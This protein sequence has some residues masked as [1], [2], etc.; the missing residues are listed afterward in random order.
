MLLLTGIIIF[1]TC[2]KN[3]DLSRNPCETKTEILAPRGYEINTI[4]EIDF[5]G[6]VKTFQFVNEQVG[7]VLAGNNRGG[8]VDVLKTT[9]GGKNWVDLNISQTQNFRGMIFKNENLGVITVHDIEGCP[10]PNCKNKCVILKTEDGGITWEEK[11]IEDL[12]GILYHPQYDNKGNLY[13]I[14]SFSNSNVNHNETQRTL[15]KSTDDGE[16]W[17]TFFSSAELDISNIKFSFEIFKDKIFAYAKDDKMLV[18]DIDGTLVKTLE[19]ENL[20]IYDIELI[21]EN[22]LI[23][24]TSTNVLKST[25]GGETWQKIHQGAARTIGFDSIDNGLMLL[26]KSS[27]IDYDVVYTND[28]IATTSNGGID[29]NEAEEG[30]TSL[31]SQFSNSQKMSD[32]SWYIMIG[33]KLLE[34]REN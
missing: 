12:K 7:Y 27:C 20:G 29:W 25:N 21:D 32:G 18:I 8:D 30:T 10:P 19:I 5:N 24:A 2:N 13:A 6:S 34:V 26:G 31:M 15:M 4:G 14:L 23:V 16:T 1:A 17:N 9:D 11:E 28:L 33:K 22:N 3:D